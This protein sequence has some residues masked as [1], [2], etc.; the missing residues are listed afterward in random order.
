MDIHELKDGKLNAR[1]SFNKKDF[2]DASKLHVCV[3]AYSL[4]G[5]FANDKETIQNIFSLN[6]K[7]DRNKSTNKERLIFN[8]E[9]PNEIS[10]LKVI[11]KCAL[12]KTRYIVYLPIYV[13]MES[14]KL[15]W[16]REKNC[17]EVKCY[18]K[19]F[20]PNND[21]LDLIEQPVSFKKQEKKF[22]EENN[23]NLFSLFCLNCC[24][25]NK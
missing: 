3:K 24:S 8:I 10:D 18:V 17:L 15:S 1:A 9:N 5:V 11:D 16:D 4:E 20:C 2:G 23:T 22:E 21:K 7:K 13:D 14:L 6:P 19:G 12:N 25:E